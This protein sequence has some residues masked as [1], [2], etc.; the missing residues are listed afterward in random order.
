MVQLSQLYVITGKTT[1]LTTGNFVSKVISLLFN[2]PCR[3]VIAFLPWSKRLLILWLQSPSTVILELKKIKSVTF[4]TFSQSICYE[5]M[6]P[7]AIILVFWMLSFQTTISLSFNS[8][9]EAFSSSLLSSMSGIICI[10]EDFIFLGSTITVDGD[11]SH[12]IKRHLLLG[13]KA[14]TNLYQTC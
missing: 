7:D 1:A 12:E 3:F 11:C 10:S 9:Q 4:S 13:R 5:V 8:H 2:I 14:M 6:G